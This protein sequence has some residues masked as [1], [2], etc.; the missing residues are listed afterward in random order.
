MQRARNGGEE[1]AIFA[2]NRSD[3][4]L[5]CAERLRRDVEATEV[6]TAL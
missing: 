1:F 3:E 5:A 6:R 4:A 2:Q